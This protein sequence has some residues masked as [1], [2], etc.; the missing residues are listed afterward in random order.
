ML[1]KRILSYLESLG[2]DGSVSITR[3]KV[4]VFIGD[5][6]L[7]FTHVDCMDMEFVRSRIDSFIS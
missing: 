5:S 7:S 2:V 6:V 3:E 4:Y 1:K